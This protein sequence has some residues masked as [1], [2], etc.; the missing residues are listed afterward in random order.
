[1]TDVNIALRQPAFMNTQ[2]SNYSASNGVDGNKTSIFHTT[3]VLPN[4]WGVDLGREDQL[5]TRVNVTN[6][7]AEK[8]CKL[9]V[10]RL[11]NTTSLFIT[12]YVAR[13]GA[14]DKKVGWSLERTLGRIVYWRVKHWAISFTLLC[15]SSLRFMNE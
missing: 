12:I 15:H 7:R 3:N 14:V 1:M 2:R 8:Y 5:V 9:S 10:S 4:W 13:S 11:Y 6:R